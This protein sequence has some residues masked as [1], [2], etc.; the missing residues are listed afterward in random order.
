MQTRL[1]PSSLL[2]RRFTTA[3]LLLLAG[4]LVAQTAPVPKPVAD[5]GVGSAPVVVKS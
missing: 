3:A 1:A 5:P 2:R 4:P